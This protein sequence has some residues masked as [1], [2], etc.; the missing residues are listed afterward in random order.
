VAW[1]QEVDFAPYVTFESSGMPF[2]NFYF[3]T[4]SRF[5]FHE[6]LFYRPQQGTILT[7]EPH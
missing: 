7:H 2:R 1:A 4:G 6:Q 3:R 5:L